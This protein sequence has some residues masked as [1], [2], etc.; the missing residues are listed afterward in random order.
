M[1]KLIENINIENLLKK[2]NG[3]IKASDAKLFGIDNKV[4]QR[5]VSYGTLE[6]VAFGLYISSETF[7][8]EYF[9][10]QYRCPK[11][12]YSYETALYFHDLSDRVPMKLTMTIPSGYNTKL[13]LEKE[14]YQFYYCKKELYEVGIVTV[15]TIY[16]NDVTVYDVERTLCECIKKVALLD[17]D[18][19]LTA[20]KRYMSD[21]RRDLSKLL[22]YAELF[23]VKDIM[24]QYMEV[25]V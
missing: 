7:P 12:I 11:G 1:I 14:Y 20:L 3:I 22:K 4:L 17:K 19:V 8:D 13:L 18:M 25:L 10:A 23:K 15:K 24:K 2:N 16:G 6:R 5:Q 21:A 9:I